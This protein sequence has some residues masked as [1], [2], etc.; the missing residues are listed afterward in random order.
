MRITFVYLD[1]A[2]TDPTYTGYFCHGIAALS[3]ILKKAGHKTSL[4]QLTKAIPE[5]EF[6]EKVRVL[7]PDLIG[8]SS[9]A[10]V[11]PF[12]IKYAKAAKK[13]IDVPIICGGVHPTICPEEVI[14]DENIDMICRGEGDLAMEELCQKMESGQSIEAVKNIWSKKRNK[15]FKNELRP[16]IT[17]LDELPYPDRE[18]FDYANLNLEKRG[19]GTF[20]FSR[21]CPYQCTF[22]CES[23]LR[24][25]YL[26]SQTY[27]R[28]RSP[29]SVVFEIKETIGKYPFIK[30]IRLDDDLLF[31]RMDWVKEFV[32]LYKKEINLP[33]SSDIRVNLMTEELL[34]LLREAGGHLL[35][36]GVESGDNFILKEILNKGITVKQIKRAFKTAKEKGF[37]VQAYNMIGLPGEGPKEI[38]ETIKLN[39]EIKADLSVVSI[40][41]PYKGTNLYELCLK[42]GY[43]KEK[44]AE[45]PKNYY[46]YS[47]LSL[48][49][50]R[51]EQISFFFNYFHLLK[52]F[53]SYLFKIPFS[54]SLIFLAGKTLSFRYAPELISAI[55]NPLRITKRKVFKIL[56]KEVRQ[57]TEAIGS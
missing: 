53:Y 19:V 18:I 12:V 27:Y 56:K 9:T 34:H 30:F 5:E 36:V 6:Q 14:K 35:R 42:K 43:F 29:R 31:A 3:A 55:F 24:K 50:I 52:K 39:A 20:M 47:V 32:P 7:N 54:R 13:A 33:F 46:S 28:F 10:H 41:Y 49:T 44:D 17:N 23:T 1:L 38:L 21:G 15:I 26:N 51:R 25:L 40:F 48:P 16:L 37:K 4:I 2:A 45:L 57:D 22:C 11:F 8:F